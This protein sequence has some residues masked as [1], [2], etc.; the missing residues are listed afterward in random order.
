MRNN[1]EISEGIATI[2][3]ILYNTTA[4][5]RFIEFKRQVSDK[6][7]NSVNFVKKKVSLEF[8]KMFTCFSCIRLIEKIAEAFML[9]V[10]MLR[11][12]LRLINP[13]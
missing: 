12:K 3:V 7:D 5:H 10:C 13:R 8:V 2:I 11:N 9:F 1:I 4:H 6:F